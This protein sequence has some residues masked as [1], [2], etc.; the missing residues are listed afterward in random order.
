MLDGSPIK[1]TKLSGYDLR[2]TT[3]FSS[4][5]ESPVM[6]FQ[7]D[8]SSLSCTVFGCPSTLHLSLVCERSRQ[9]YGRAMVTGDDLA[10][11]SSPCS[12]AP[13]GQRHVLACVFLRGQ[14]ATVEPQ[15]EHNYCS[16]TSRSKYFLFRPCLFARWPS[17][18]RGWTHSQ[19]RGTAER[20]HV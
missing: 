16:H 15:Y 3:C 10:I 1:I 20:L 13:D 7:P 14:P 5:S 6:L 11:Y 2:E 18:C 4:P 8:E 17:A 19:L 9:L 12:S